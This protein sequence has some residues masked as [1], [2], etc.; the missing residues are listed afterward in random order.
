MQD[1]TAQGIMGKLICIYDIGLTD[2]ILIVL[3]SAWVRGWQ[4]VITYFH[5]VLGSSWLRLV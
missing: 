5:S 4:N 2:D 1:I 3:K